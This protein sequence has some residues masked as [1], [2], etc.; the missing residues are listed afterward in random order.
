MKLR[1][2]V[3]QAHKDF[4]EV[5]DREEWDGSGIAEEDFGMSVSAGGAL[6]LSK[7]QA[8]VLKRSESSTDIFSEATTLPPSPCSDSGFSIDTPPRHSQS[9][10]LT[11]DETTEFTVLLDRPPSK[12]RIRD[13]RTIVDVDSYWQERLASMSLHGENAKQEDLGDIEWEHSTCS[14]HFPSEMDTRQATRDGALSVP[15]QAPKA[16]KVYAHADRTGDVTYQ[17]GNRRVYGDMVGLRSHTATT[18][19]PPST[20]GACNVM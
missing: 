14:T 9:L 13:R 4:K 20:D 8:T 6:I 18:P 19:T 16:I 15:M 11:F 5:D 17:R 1:R 2:V 7:T 3:C 12:T 10:S